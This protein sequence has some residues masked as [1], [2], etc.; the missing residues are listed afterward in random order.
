MKKLLE[1]GIFTGLEAE[2]IVIDRDNGK[3]IGYIGNQ[4]IF[5]FCGVDFSK[6]NYE[7]EGGEDTPEVSTQERI[8]ELE[9]IIAD[10][11]ELLIENEVI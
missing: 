7:V 10:L 9:Q 2:K 1:N 5:S 8:A 11:S 6:V 3:V 4:E